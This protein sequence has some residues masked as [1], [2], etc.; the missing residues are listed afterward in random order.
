MEIFLPELH[1]WPLRAFLDEASD[2]FGEDALRELLNSYGLQLQDFV[3]ASA[4]ISLEFVEALLQGMVELA[5]DPEFFDRATRR[6]M[7]AKY[8]GPLYPLFR[9]FGSPRFSYNQ[10]ARAAGRVNKTGQ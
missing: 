3:D 8:I 4:W 10:L 9:A 2:T 1:N 6:G 7:S 5:G